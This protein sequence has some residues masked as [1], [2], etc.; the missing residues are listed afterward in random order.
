MLAEQN[1]Q[2]TKIAVYNKD[3]AEM[4]QFIDPEHERLPPANRPTYQ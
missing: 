2:C 3:G 1:S 4:V